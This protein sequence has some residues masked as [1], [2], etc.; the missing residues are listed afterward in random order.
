MLSVHYLYV[1]ADADDEIEIETSNNNNNRIPRWLYFWNALALF[2]YYTLDCM[3]GKQARRTNSSSPL[4]QL[5]D[6]GVDALGNVSHVQVIQCIVQVPPTLLVTLQCSLQTAFFQAQWEEY[7]TGRL[8]HATGNVGVTEVTYGMALWSFLTGVF[9]R[10]IYERRLVV[11]EEFNHWLLP[12]HVQSLL[13]W[14]IGGLDE[15]QVRHVASILW[16]LMIVG[17]TTLSYI[18]VYQ[19]VGGNIRVFA[20]AL[21][22]LALGPWLLSY[23]GIRI[24]QQPTL[25]LGLAFCWIPIKIIVFSMARMAY[26]S[27]QWSILP[28]V[29]VSVWLRYS[30]EYTWWSHTMMKQPIEWALDLYYVLSISFWAYRAISQLCDKLHIK[31]FRI[32]SPKGQ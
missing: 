1:N 14:W 28:L 11:L 18:R 10:D 20:S 9:G 26:A 30:P 17:L 7:Y 32:A 13:L 16:I 27:F 15:L 2:I 19:H 22:K 25:A 4:G 8:P 29:T 6:H 23:V 12:S 3:D 24:N 21:S 5:F 31:L